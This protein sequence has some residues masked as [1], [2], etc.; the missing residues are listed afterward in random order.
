MNKAKIVHSV[1]TQQGSR[2]YS[3]IG[4]AVE[5]TLTAKPHPL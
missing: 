5:T 1:N 4:Q 3:G 2:K